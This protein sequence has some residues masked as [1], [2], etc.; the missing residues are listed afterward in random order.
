[1]GPNY[2][3]RLAAQLFEIKNIP[4][5]EP[6]VQKNFNQNL[7]KLIKIL[8][9]RMMEI[10]QINGRLARIEIEKQNIKREEL[11]V[12]LARERVELIKNSQQQSVQRAAVGETHRH[13]CSEA[14]A[15]WFDRTYS[16]ILLERC[17]AR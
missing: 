10:A 1:M 3:L 7:Q 17:G 2:L 12:E 11:L 6:V 15:I 5:V 14:F 4:E 13:V 9:I 8:K 16:E